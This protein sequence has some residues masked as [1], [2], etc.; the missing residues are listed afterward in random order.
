V[1]RE[2]VNKSKSNFN[3][4]TMKAIGQRFEMFTN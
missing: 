2:E 3:L 4:I 1:N